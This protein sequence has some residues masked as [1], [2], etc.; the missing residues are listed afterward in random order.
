MKTKLNDII[1]ESE[2]AI[3]KT[4]PGFFIHRILDKDLKH[5]RKDCPYDIVDTVFVVIENKYLS[6]YNEM[7][8]ASEKRNMNSYIAR[9]V[10]S[11][12]GLK[13][14]GR[15]CT[16]PKSSLIKSHSLLYDF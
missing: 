3:S 16:S 4:L 15:V 9:S 7:C 13:N 5:L 12:W 8:I 6:M 10:K 11:I 14:T 1:T 2:S